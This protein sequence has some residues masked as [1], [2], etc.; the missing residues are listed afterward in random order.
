LRRANLGASAFAQ[1]RLAE[2][3]FPRYDNVRSKIISKIGKTTIVSNGIGYNH[4][5]FQMVLNEKAFRVSDGAL[6]RARARVQDNAGHL[7][8]RSKRVVFVKDTAPEIAAWDLG[9]GACLRVQGIPRLDLV[10]VA[11]RVKNRKV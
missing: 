1:R 4:V 8:L 11:W 7:L 10:V 3:A 6:A 5:N 2:D 9:A